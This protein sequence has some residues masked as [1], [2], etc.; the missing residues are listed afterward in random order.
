M[1]DSIQPG[2]T[3][4][5]PSPLRWI[6]AFAFDTVTIYV[7]T[8]RISPM[9]VA[10]W[11][12][13]LM[14]AFQLHTVVQPADWY[15]QHLELMTIGSAIAA[16]YMDIVR[17]VPALVGKL[18]ID[19]RNAPATLWAWSIP[20]VVLVV[21]M[22][23]YRA[24]S[25]VFS[26]SSMSAFRYFF[27][28]VPHITTVQDILAGDPER[29]LRQMRVTAPFYAGSAYSLGALCHKYKVVEVTSLQSCILAVVAK[30]EYFLT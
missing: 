23:S 30:S 26:G 10:L 15:A 9:L 24:P 6:A 21:E 7:L 16:G 29:I 5:R 17:F 2:V 8:L 14:P 4:N 12:R 28:I 27:E 1:E 3:E 18:A 25:S 13:Y 22:V 11:F 19:R 20:A